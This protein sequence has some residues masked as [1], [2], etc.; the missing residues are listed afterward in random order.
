MLKSWFK[1]SETLA[2]ARVQMVAGGILEV[3]AITDLTPLFNAVGMPKWAPVWL[4]AT[5]VLTEVLRRRRA[6]DL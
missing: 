2:F 1:D 4:M 3:V 5:G 6:T